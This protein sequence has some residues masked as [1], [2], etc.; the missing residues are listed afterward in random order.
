MNTHL[1]TLCAEQILRPL[2]C[3]FAAMLAP[4]SHPLLQ[5]VFALLSA[6]TGGGHVCLPLSRIIPAAEQGGRHAEIM[7]SVWRA[8]NEP[9]LPEI[10]AALSASDAVS[11]G[12]LPAPV[13]LSEE[14]LYL[15][16]MWQYECRWLNFSPGLSG[17]LLMQRNCARFWMHCSVRKNRRT[18]RKLPQR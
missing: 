17:F 7:Q 1:Q 3:Q 2:D 18:G 8:L 13:V 4:D 5:F 15:H 12:S 14:N 6:Q 16:R 9:G 10:K 11:D